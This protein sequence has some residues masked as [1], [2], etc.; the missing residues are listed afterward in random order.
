MMTAVKFLKNGSTVEGKEIFLVVSSGY[1]L[2]KLYNEFETV[3]IVPRGNIR[4]PTRD[5]L[6]SQTDSLMSAYIFLDQED[7]FLFRIKYN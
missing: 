3:H 5:Y 1:E 2:T 4:Q 7:A 6:I